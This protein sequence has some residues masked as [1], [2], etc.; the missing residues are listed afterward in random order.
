MHSLGDEFCLFSHGR[1]NGLKWSRYC[2]LADLL[3][4]D[5]ST[6]V[7]ENLEMYEEAIFD[8]CGVTMDTVSP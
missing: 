8:V 4:E 6:Y 3:K 7:D 1:L 2:G 5:R